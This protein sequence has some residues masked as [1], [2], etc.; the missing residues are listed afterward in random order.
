[1]MKGK[2]SAIYLLIFLA[3]FFSGLSTGKLA[4]DNMVTI[5]YF[6]L[7]II[8]FCL[9][10]LAPNRQLLHFIKQHLLVLCLAAIL[11]SVVL[12]YYN[13]SIAENSFI[14]L[15]LYA[16]L[17][18]DLNPYFELCKNNKMLTAL[19]ILWLISISIS[20]FS[21]PYGLLNSYLSRIR[22]EHTFVHV[23]CFISLLVFSQQ[24]KMTLDKLLLA[25]SAS[26]CLLGL[27]S[28]YLY[29]SLD[30]QEIS[31][32]S[33]KF[34]P[35]FSNNVRN[36]GYQVMVGLIV[37]LSY[38]AIAKQSNARLFVVSLLFSVMVF[39][40][41][42]LFWLGGRT[43]IFATL[44]V[45]ALIWLVLFLRGGHWRFFIKTSILSSLAG[46]VFAEWISVFP[47]NG[48]FKNIDR[49]V[50]ATVNM[51]VPGRF[52]VW[53][54]VWNAVHE[55]LFFGLGARAFAYIPYDGGRMTHPHNLFAQV[56]GEWGLVGSV[57]FLAILSAA[58]IRGYKLH[59]VNFDTERS[60]RALVGGMVIVGLTVHAL[61]DG[62][63]YYA[64]PVLN[65]L[66]AF[67]IWVLPI[68]A[69]SPD[70][71]PSGESPQKDESPRE[72]SVKKTGK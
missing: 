1:M 7:A 45:V 5:L 40:W 52:N 60:L 23:V 28:I 66:M 37:L 47:W 18:R 27:Y 8:F 26:V 68:Y 44:V 4:D 33:W 62:T 2:Y 30:P 25:V 10:S 19:V 29:L 32:A 3:V 55:H 22:F 36:L 63:Y 24:S 15:V 54:T 34:A 38:I 17:S 57:L 20:F 13:L 31:S 61:T 11:V 53:D 42:F 16:C 6:E 70:S 71:K 43:S 56:L 59:I 39:L 72:S 21:S 41:G 64:Q 48:L 69:N 46:I 65:L 51:Q 14:L 67:A 35:P 9:L 49:V 58:F 50:V 12:V